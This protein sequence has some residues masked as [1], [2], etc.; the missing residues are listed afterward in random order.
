[1]AVINPFQDTL[2]PN[3]TSNIVPAA[4][5]VP[6][7]NTGVNPL[8]IQYLAAAG[9]DLLSGNPIGANVNAVTNQAVQNKSFVKLLQQMLGQAQSPNNT[10]KMTMDGSKFKFEGDMIDDEGNPFLN[11]STSPLDISSVDLAGLTPELISQALNFKMTQDQL[12]QKKISDYVDMIY[13]G[14]LTDQALAAAEKSRNVDT[15]T[16]NI[17]EYEY[18]RDNQ[19]FD[20]TLREWI[21]TDPISWK[22][23]QKDRGQG[24]EDTYHNW[25]REQSSLKGGLSLPEFEKRKEV[26]EDIQARKYFTDPKGLAQDVDKHIASE[27]VQNSLFTYADNPRELQRQTLLA[28]A[29]YVESKI[30]SSGGKVEDVSMDGRTRVW[31]VKWPDG[32]VSEVRYGF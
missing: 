17:K 16:G 29:K 32:K 30:T 4:G 20:G 3:P 23:Y 11:P 7:T 14:A 13:K 27:E 25:L 1:M 6:N 31:K 22:E 8:L 2:Y 9:S 21:S 19:G 5:N 10:S 18:A 15:R 24:Y 26:T 28:K 12:A